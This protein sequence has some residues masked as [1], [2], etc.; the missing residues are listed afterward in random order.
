MVSAAL[1]RVV[2]MNYAAY[3]MLRAPSAVHSMSDTM[4][5][6]SCSSTAS[7]QL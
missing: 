7:E 3:A 6:M 2:C 5:S 4:Q 1:Q